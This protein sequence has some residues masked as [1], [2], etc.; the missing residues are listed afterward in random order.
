MSNTKDPVCFICLKDKNLKCADICCKVK[1]FHD[2]C[3]S[4]YCSKSD[5]ILCPDCKKN[6][7]DKFVV[8][9]INIT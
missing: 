2:E 3:L 8:K 5:K 1:E 6:I 4:A 9:S 7:T